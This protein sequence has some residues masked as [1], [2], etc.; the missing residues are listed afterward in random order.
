MGKTKTVPFNKKGISNL[1]KDK[2][3]IYK[4][5]TNADKNNY[6]GTAKRGRVPD[7]L[8]EHLGEIPGAM[9]KFKLN[10]C[11]ALQQLGK[12]NQI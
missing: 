7:R 12:K 2:P 3:V 10:K 1:P 5:L 11:L 6:T 8:A 9:L 4:I